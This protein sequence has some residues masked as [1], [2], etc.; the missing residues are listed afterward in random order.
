MRPTEDDMLLEVA[1][2]VSQRATCSRLSVGAVLA[3]EGRILSTG[4]N[5]A[6]SGMNHCLHTNDK[7]CKTAVHAEANAIAFAAKHGVATYESTLY[8][9]HSP[10]L[11]CS[12]LIINAGIIRVVYWL[13]YR[14]SGPLDLLKSA[15]LGV[16]SGF[17]GE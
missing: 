6:P 17:L 10:C 8:T 12:H 5:G 4:Y 1:R 7:P 14:D 9:T 15:G 11:T 3:I 13:V 2:V 16:D